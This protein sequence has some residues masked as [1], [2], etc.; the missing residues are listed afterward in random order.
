MN[1]L[2]ARQAI[3][4]KLRAASATIPAQTSTV[5]TFIWEPVTSPLEQF[6]KLL[7]ANHA[8]VIETNK[9]TVGEVIGE[10]IQKNNYQTAV[11]SDRALN[12]YAA[13]ALHAR[14]LPD[15]NM[16]QW[17]TFLF[18]STDVG[19]TDAE[20]AIASTGTLVIK[21]GRDEPRS[22]SLV[23]PAHI[24]LVKANSLYNDFA[25]VIQK[26]QWNSGMPT[27]RV[28]LSGPSKTADIQQT[29]AYGAHGPAR[30]FVVIIH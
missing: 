29:L 18:E 22:L 1:T 21:P 24:I 15:G 27:N 20:C 30:L 3:M 12:N 11:A 6:K 25:E 17:K 16:E 7:I 10:I 28:L 2:S 14:A 5:P 9:D 23:P 26:Q 13:L 8:D 19:I 4:K